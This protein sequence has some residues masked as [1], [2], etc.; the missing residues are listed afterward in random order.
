[1]VRDPKRFPWLVGVVT[2]GGLTVP[3]LVA[4]GAGLAA[5]LFVGSS[6]HV[7]STFALFAFADVRRHARMHPR[8]YVAAPLA[9]AGAAATAAAL[10]PVQ[11]LQAAL[12]AFFGWQLWHYQQQNLGL[13]A[14]VARAT[15]RPP[16]TTRERRGIRISAA[17]AVLALA[18]HPH[19][20]QA[21]ALTPPAAVTVA[22]TGAAW[23]LIAVAFAMQ[24]RP[25]TLL[26]V[27]FPLPLLLTTS[28]YAA[29]GGMT[30][31]HG[32]Q[33][34]L[35]V[36]MVLAGPAHNG[37]PR[38]PEATLLLA[39][40]L[41]VAGALAAAS[42]LHRGPAAT[43]AVFGVYAGVVMAHFV[44]DAGLW[45]LR[46]PFPR[47]WLGERLPELLRPDTPASDIESVPWPRPAMPTPSSSPAWPKARSTATR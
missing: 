37:K 4:P 9:L 21:V 39:G 30:L 40:V 35:L 28:P 34:L 47:R 17:A 2:L 6:V 8:R 11:L 5:L 12:L 18:A 16:L 24:R 27:A 23:L 13:A 33:Y 10:L 3:A 36:A 29:L 41:A 26:A 32:L 20:T 25:L 14:L 15:G 43:K 42:H 7:A 22:A 38:L 45:R 19:V 31:A 1:M 46:D 44:L